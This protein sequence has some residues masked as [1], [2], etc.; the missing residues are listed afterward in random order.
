M[1]VVKFPFSPQKHQVRKCSLLIVGNCLERETEIRMK[2]YND[3]CNAQ[4]FNLIIYLL[5]S[6]MF[7]AF[8]YPSSETGVQ[9][10]QWFKSLGYGVSVR[11]RTPYPGDLNHCRSCTPASEY[12][13]TEIQKHVRQK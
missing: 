2:L 3:H 10:L 7:R 5:L 1:H 4:V 11:V 13:L 9:L 6:Y 12:G 8:F